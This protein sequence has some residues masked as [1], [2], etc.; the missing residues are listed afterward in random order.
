LSRSPI[1]CN[2]AR[3]R[4][5]MRSLAIARPMAA[6]RSCSLTGLVRKSTAPAFIARTLLGTSPWP[7]RKTMGR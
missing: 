1:A 7:L 4:R 2:S 6:S 3:T 5:I